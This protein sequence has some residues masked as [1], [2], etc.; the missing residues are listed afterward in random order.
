[1]SRWILFGVIIILLII[2]WVRHVLY[3]NSMVFLIVNRGILAPNCPWWNV[4]DA[5]LSDASGVNLYNELKKTHGKIIPMNMFGQRIFLVTDIDFVREI[6]HKSPFIFGVGKLKY[7][8]FKSFMA[9]NVGVSEGEAWVTRRQLNE[10]VLFTDQLHP[11]AGMYHKFIGQMFVNDVLPLNYKEFLYCSKLLAMKVVFGENNINPTVF[12]IFPEANTMC[13]IIQDNY[14]INPEM[15]D[16]FITYLRQQIA[17]PKS[18]SL[19]SIAVTYTTSESELLNQI[20]HWIFPIVGL[21]PNT[22]ARLMVLLCNHPQKFGILIEELRLCDDLTSPMKVYKLQ[23]LRYCILETM[24]LNNPVVTTFRTLLADYCF[25]VDHCYKKGDQ[26]LILNNPI[27]RDFEKP[28]EFIPERWENISEESDRVVMFNHGPQKC[29]GKELVMFLLGST[30]VN[31]CTCSGILE[32]G[33]QILRC[34]KIDVYNIPQM[35]NP[36]KISFSIIE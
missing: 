7:R 19:V 24:R 12:K 26:F 35:I 14:E 3:L 21:M 27:L 23:Y 22:F 32:Y 4:S 31:F 25:D 34:D 16:T 6:L 29:P 10:K 28:N 5:L 33:Y 11:Y 17:N 36:C 1:M 15:K 9:K 20:P 30:F 13:S 2:Y 18:Y 8:M